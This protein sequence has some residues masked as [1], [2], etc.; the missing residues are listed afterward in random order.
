MTV[1]GKCITYDQLKCSWFYEG[2]L[3]SDY[4]ERKALKVVKSDEDK[5]GIIDTILS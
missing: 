2:V 4:F 3:F 1:N 5:P